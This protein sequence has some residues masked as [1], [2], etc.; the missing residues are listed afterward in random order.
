MRAEA[1]EEWR[2]ERREW[3]YEW[4]EGMGRLWVELAVEECVNLEGWVEGLR[5]VVGR[6]EGDGERVGVEV[7]VGGKGLRGRGGE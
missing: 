6:G 3:G 2:V 7:G 1:A 4:W 5:G